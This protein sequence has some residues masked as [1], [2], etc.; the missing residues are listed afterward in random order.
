MFDIQYSYNT[1]GAVT[2]SMTS[3]YRSVSGIPFQGSITGTTL[4]VSAM[5]LPIPGTI[6]IGM[7]VSGSGVTLGTYIVSQTSGTTGGAGDYVVSVSQSVSSTLMCNTGGLAFTVSTLANAT[8]TPM[9]V[10]AVVGGPIPIGITDYFIFGRDSSNTWIAS[11]STAVYITAGPSGGGTGNYTISAAQTTS[12][13]AATVCVLV[14]YQQIQPAASNH[15]FTATSTWQQSG[16]VGFTSFQGLML[17]NNDSVVTAGHFSAGLQYTILSIGNTDF[18]AIGATAIATFTGYISSSTLTVSTLTTGTIANNLYITGTGILPNTYITVFG[19]GTGGVGTYILNNSQTVASVGS[20]IAIVLQPPLGTIFTATAT[21]YTSIH[22]S[23]K[24][25]GKTPAISQYC[26]G[27]FSQTGSLSTGFYQVG[28]GS[29]TAR[30][31]SVPT[32]PLTSRNVL[33][34]F[35]NTPGRFVL[36][37]TTT[38]NLG[39]SVALDNIGFINHNNGH[40]FIFDWEASTTVADA[41]ITSTVSNITVPQNSLFSFATIPSTVP[42]GQWAIQSVASTQNTSTAGP[43]TNAYTVSTGASGAYVIVFTANPL[44]AYPGQLMSGATNQG[45]LP[46]V[47]GSFSALNSVTATATTGG[48]VNFTVNSDTGSYFLYYG[49]SPTAGYPSINMSVTGTS[50]AAN[51][52]VTAVYPNIG[53]MVINNATTETINAGTVA[54]GANALTTGA[55]TTTFS[56]QN[57]NGAIFQ[58]ASISGTNVPANAIVL[59]SQ[60]ISS[61]GARV[62]VI[63]LTISS[64]PSGTITISSAAN[65]VS[66]TVAN[67]GTVSGTGTFSTG[68]SGTTYVQTFYASAVVTNFWLL[69]P[70]INYYNNPFNHAKDSNGVINLPNVEIGVTTSVSRQLVTYRWVTLNGTSTTSTPVFYLAGGVLPPGLSL[71]TSG[72]ISGTITTASL[73]EGENPYQF[74]VQVFYSLPTTPLQ[75]T[76]RTSFIQAFEMTITKA[77]T[78]TVIPTNN[79]EL[80]TATVSITDGGR[81][82]LPPVTLQ[83]NVVNPINGTADAVMRPATVDK[84]QTPVIVIG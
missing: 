39:C 57:S 16:I 61:T 70:E 58:G 52:I 50:V 56:G 55:P 36:Q 1:K 15:T 74:S 63:N 59:Y 53:M 78:S 41:F 2:G 64:A 21:N 46:Y 82:P 40:N 23:I 11:S 20:P 83:T 79:L 3:Y 43:T 35:T 22:N 44:L 5:Y 25:N 10:T 38:A 75:G 48:A 24:P 37:W 29:G 32:T 28:T 42:N 84:L 60:A 6:T 8:I 30:H 14:R 49:T 54:V 9:N 13:A 51:T 71:S 73:A 80:V 27:N 18:T 76:V 65:S 81:N 68:N 26:Q 77:I 62:Y 47:I 34:G 67:A 17:T 69:S 19:T 45:T 7:G 31:I 72:L 4:T 33:N 66:V 12:L